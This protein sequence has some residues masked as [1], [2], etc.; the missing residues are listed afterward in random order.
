M[1]LIESIRATLPDV[2]LGSVILFREYLNTLQKG[3]EQR[4]HNHIIAEKLKLNQTISHRFP[5]K[6]LIETMIRIEDATMFVLDM[7][8]PEDFL[9]PAI[10]I[11]WNF[12]LQDGHEYLHTYGVRERL[13]NHARST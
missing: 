13:L 5:H 1:E 12:V 8:I 10:R 4:D 3:F 6:I 2:R 7:I 11:D 9:I